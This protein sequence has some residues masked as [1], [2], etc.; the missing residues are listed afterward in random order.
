MRIDFSGR[1]V[2]IT[3]RV[4]SFTIGKLDR[5]TKHLD[6]IQ[7]VTVV[8]SVEKYRHK[9]EIKFLSRKRTFVCAEETN[10]M[11]G[12]IDR[13]VDKLEAQAKK[14]KEKLNGKK[15]NTHESIR[16]HVI[17]SPLQERAT[18]V[19]ADRELK[20]IRTDNSVVK[21]MSLEEAVDE[22]TNF[23]QE[24]IIFRNHESDDYNVVYRRKDGHIGYIEPG[25]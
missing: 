15:R 23:D 2:D 8:L 22:L 13:V 16:H 25:A 19:L 18:D 9:A 10:D 3:D 14:A 7:D 5:L 20:I 6:D 24:F 4:R 1:G 11:F 17:S 21:P 12:S